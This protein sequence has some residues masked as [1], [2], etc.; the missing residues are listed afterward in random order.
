MA[1]PRPYRS[2]PVFNQDTLPAA[3]RARHDTKAGVWG[4]I[5]VIE[6]AL[7]LT[8]IDPPSEVTLTPERP[9]L[10]RPQQPH[11]VTPVGT[12]KMQVD[13]YDQAPPGH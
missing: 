5:R 9:G 4:V 13:F 3:L 7:T 11:F 2:T 12:M 1:E 8:Y 6:G 10:V